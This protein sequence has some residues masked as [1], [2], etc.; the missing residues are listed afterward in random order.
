MPPA[1][2]RLK[3]LDFPATVSASDATTLSSVSTTLAAGS[4]SVNLTFVA[5]TAGKALLIVGGLTRCTSSVQPIII[6]WEMYLGTGTGG[7]LILGTG[8][9]A[10]RLEQVSSSTIY[11]HNGS[12][13]VLITGLTPGATYFV[14]TMHQSLVAATGDVLLRYLIVAPTT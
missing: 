6:D 8:S 3:S 2:Q 10:R 1:G 12:K 5:N 9:Q 7:T 4:P 13:T 14:R 11:G